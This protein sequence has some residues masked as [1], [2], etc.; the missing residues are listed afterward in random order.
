MIIG[1]KEKIAFEINECIPPLP[2]LKDVYMWIDNKRIGNEA[3]YYA[4]YC[5]CAES[6]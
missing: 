1:N 3:P 2:I 4:T 6:F 5:S